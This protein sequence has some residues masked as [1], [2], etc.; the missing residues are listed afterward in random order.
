M[1]LVV[2]HFFSESVFIMSSGYLEP[3]TFYF[4]GFLGGGGFW[5]FLRMELFRVRDGFDHI[6]AFL[7]KQAFLYVWA[8][9]KL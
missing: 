7:A 8:R 3:H 5:G 1:S 2:C 6:V 4:S 9:T